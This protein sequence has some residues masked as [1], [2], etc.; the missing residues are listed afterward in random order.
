MKRLK[1]LL[2]LAYEFADGYMA[3]LP[4]MENLALHMKENFGKFD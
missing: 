1:N 2:A 4:H 3:L